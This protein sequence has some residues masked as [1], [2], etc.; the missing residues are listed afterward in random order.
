MNNAITVSNLTKKYKEFLLDGISFSVPNGY[1]CGFIGQNGAGK[2]TT[3]MS[4]SFYQLSHK[5]FMRLSLA[6]FI[7]RFFCE[8]KHCGFQYCSTV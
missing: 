6:C 8:L 2:T 4:V 7:R 5:S 1:I 3:M